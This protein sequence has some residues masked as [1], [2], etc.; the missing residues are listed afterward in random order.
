MINYYLGFYGIFAD[1]QVFSAERFFAVAEEISEGAA[2]FLKERSN[3]DFED[4]LEALYKMFN[5]RK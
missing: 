4:Y 1:N 5:Y 2:N 3:K